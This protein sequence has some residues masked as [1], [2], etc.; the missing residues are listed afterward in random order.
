MVP[1]QC[2]G[3]QRRSCHCSDVSSFYGFQSFYYFITFAILSTC[4]VVPTIQR[5]VVVGH[6]MDNDAFDDIRTASSHTHDTHDLHH[7]HHD[8]AMFVMNDGNHTTGDMCHD[9]YMTMYMDG[10]HWSLFFQHMK[11]PKMICL[12]YFVSTWKVQYPS[13]FRGCM[14]Y[15]FLLAIL[16]EA[17][18]SIRAVCGQ[19]FQH[20]RSS[21]VRGQHHIGSSFHYRRRLGLLEVSRHIITIILYA[22]QT[23]IG[24]LIMLIVMSYSMEL[25]LSILF[26]LIIGNGL[27]VRYTNNTNN[28]DS[29]FDDFDEDDDDRENDSPATIDIIDETQSLLPVS[30]RSRN[31]PI[32]GI[33]RRRG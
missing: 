14:I 13:E 18:S 29:R 21:I 19:Y 16:L 2:K 25:L 1:T 12:N 33:I 10:F 17:L 26:G 3:L 6:A 5:Y 11:S 32:D 24:Y 15:T 22:F 8:H 7:H 4:I 9:M 20:Q 28:E 27:F 30:D 23:I 31:R